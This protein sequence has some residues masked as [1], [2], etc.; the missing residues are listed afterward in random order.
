MSSDWKGEQSD[1]MTSILP[2]LQGPG[3]KLISVQ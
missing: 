3:I 1:K 2:F